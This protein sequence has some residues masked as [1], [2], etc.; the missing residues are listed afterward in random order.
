LKVSDEIKIGLIILF[1]IGSLVWGINFLKGTNLFTDHKVFYAIYD[2]V[3]GLDRSSP[4]RVNGFKVGKIVELKMSR[5]KNVKV[6]IKFRIE[7]DLE[8]TKDTKAMIVNLDLLGSKG[9]DLTIG[10]GPLAARG[11]TLPS[12]IERS[13]SQMMNK[14]ITPI[15]AKAANLMISLDSALAV[16]RSVFNKQ[17]QENLIMVFDKLRSTTISLNDAALKMDS[18]VGS[19]QKRLKHIFLNIDAITTTL[20]NNN[21]NISKILKDFS[22]ISDS[23]SKSNIKTTIFN[24]NR[25]MEE[26]SSVFQKINK[27]EGSLGLLVNNDSLYNNLSNTSYNLDML[28]QD[29]K[30][31]PKQYVH[32]SIFGGSGKKK[33]KPEKNSV[34]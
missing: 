19:E 17:T 32:F 29:I 28:I 26:V 6:I 5:G 20:K 24:T 14:E 8:I 22:S 33:E 9:I 30:K 4:V 21:E 16:V 1:A 18:L 7:G 10:T 11:D 15:A 13:L 3:D 31:N 12:E 23:I 27:G 34:K 25:V 2:R